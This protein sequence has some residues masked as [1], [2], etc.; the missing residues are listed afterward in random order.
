MPA[1]I[2]WFYLLGI[3][4]FAGIG[5]MLMT[6]SYRYSRASDIAPYKYLHVLFTA[7]IGIFFLGES[8]DPLSLLGSA[9]IVGV[10]IYLYKKR[11]V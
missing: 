1:P 11:C 8:M 4:V 3:G 6:E 5:Q 7:L 2:Q 9:I 10:F